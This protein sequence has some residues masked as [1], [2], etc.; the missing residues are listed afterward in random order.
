M[1]GTA[2][3]S[4][5]PADGFLRN[6]VSR[7]RLS[8]VQ[9]QGAGYALSQALVALLA[10]VSTV[11]VARAL[12]AQAFGV[13]SFAVAF[14]TFTAMFFDFGLFLPAARLVAR[15]SSERERHQTV[16][17]ALLAFVPVGLLFS[18][19]VFGL[20]FF[21]D[22]W[23]NVE[24]SHALQ[25]ISAIAFVYPLSYVGQ[26]L[27]K[28]SGRLHVFSVTSA[29]AQALYV[30]SLIAGLADHVH[31]TAS[32]VII[33]RLG[34]MLVAL[35]VLVVWL[36]PE[37]RGAMRR[38]PAILR[39]TRDYGIQMYLGNVMSMGTY[40]MDVLMLGAL[41]NARTVGYY[42]LAGSAAYVVALP[43][44]GLAAAL[45]S[46]MTFQHR[47]ARRW[48]A[49]GWVSGL[50]CAIGV[51]ALAYP[52]LPWIL[53]SRYT[54]AIVLIPPLALAAVVQGVTTIYNTYL[55]AQAKGT[56]LRNAAL[57]LTLSNLVLN[58]A[59]IPPFGAL[60]AAWA[61]LAALV[62]NLFAHMIFYRRYV[63]ARERLVGA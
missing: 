17:A 62:V 18:A 47:I 60:G 2:T 31:L 43:V 56:E 5:A 49:F 15:S 37:F 58:L 36:S 23:F 10:A 7:R 57:I 19:T 9:L 21:V 4:P 50:V 6:G 33:L 55:A 13:Q 51:S 44:N 26:Y 45:F 16:G 59:L 52:L 35:T 24:A 34:S 41:T 46:R 61:S 53:S 48:L 25:L 54:G 27:A 63:G 11:L 22:S 1:N 8:A 20:S 3:A 42:S 30:L 32:L 28:G 14:L 29:T 38:I 39:D 40:S 12:S